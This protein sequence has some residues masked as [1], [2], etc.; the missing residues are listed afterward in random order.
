VLFAFDGTGNSDDLNDPAMA[1][2]GFSNVV[3]FLGAYP[4]AKRYISGVGTVHH[5]IE[6]GDIRPEDYATGR[7]LWWLTPG[8][9]VHA[10]DMGGNYSG[11]ARIERMSQYLDDEA[12]LFSDDRVMDIDVVGFSR[13]A[14]QAREFAN[15]IVAKTVRHEG[16]LYYPYTN[17]RGDSACQAVKFRFMGLFDTVL[18]TNFSG[19]AYRLGIPEAFA[20]VA[21]AVALNEHRSDSLTE[22]GYRNP[23]LH[24]MH[25]GGF[26]LESIGASSDV[27]GRIRIEKGFVGAHADIGGGYPDAE[28]GLSR[29]ALAWMVRQAELAGVNMKEVPRIPRHDVALHDQSSVIEIGNPRHSVV[30]RPTGNGD[31]PGIDYVFPEDREVSGAVAGDRQRSMQFDNG[32]LTHADTLRYITWLPRDATRRGD[33]SALDPRRL[34]DITAT[35]DMARYLAWLEQPENGYAA[36][37]GGF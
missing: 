7:L 15:R 16:Q 10:N 9:P 24:N 21:Q 13:G 20:H 19:E 31:L 35:V 18:S 4:D 2:S 29:V 12:E 32:S 22:F 27:L 17:H 37:N 3:Y 8:D 5:D 28:Q 6:Y 34:G 11:P 14:A 36:K 33:G 23:K 30:P 25:W 26:P 1:G